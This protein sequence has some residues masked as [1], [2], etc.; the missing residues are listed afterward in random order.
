MPVGPQYSGELTGRDFMTTA[1]CETST[2]PQQ[3]ML[4][5]QPQQ[6]Q[7]PEDFAVGADELVRGRQELA[8]DAAMSRRNYIDDLC[9]V[10]NDSVSGYHYGLQ[11]CESCKGIGRLHFLT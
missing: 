3:P 5:S 6:P 7:L 1:G 10:C 11:T 2:D 9:P 4:Q 8:L